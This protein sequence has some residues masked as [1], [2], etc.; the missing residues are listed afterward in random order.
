[1]ATAAKQVPSS[2]NQIHEAR[3][4]P[5]AVIRKN[6]RVR[7]LSR[8]GTD[9]TRSYPWIAEV[10]LK[11]QQKRFVIDG[12]AVIVGVDASAT[13]TRCTA[14]NTTTSGNQAHPYPRMA[15]I[16]GCPTSAPAWRF[17]GSKTSWDREACRSRGKRQIIPNDTRLL[18]L[19]NGNKHSST[20]GRTGAWFGKSC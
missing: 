5:D 14:D 16:S 17:S 2:P 4:L 8:N 12:E 11:T 6:E 10:A 1:M 7:L 15:D 18:K 3:W 20:K 13:S 19:N 9:W